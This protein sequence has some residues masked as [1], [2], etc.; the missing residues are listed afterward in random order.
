MPNVRPEHLHLGIVLKTVGLSD[1][2]TLKV[3]GLQGA[4]GFKITSGYAGWEEIE[5]PRR[6]SVVN[7]K[8]A[9]PM[10]MV[11]DLLLDTWMHVPEESVD[12]DI[13][14]LELM[15]GMGTKAP[16]VPPK[17]KLW[18]AAHEEWPAKVPHS[19]FAWYIWDLTWGDCLRNT[20][21]Q[22]KRQQCRVELVEA[23]TTDSIRRL[24]PVVNVEAP[25]T[26]HGRL[27]RTPGNPRL[28]GFWIV[29]KGDT[30]QFIAKECYQNANKWRLIA[31]ANSI[32]NTKRLVPG[33]KLKIPRL[34]Q[35]LHETSGDEGY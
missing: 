28:K 18:D 11:G 9:S 22:T 1:E 31:R 2:N 32:H 21:G 13:Y 15:A 17:I 4:E 29:K 19:N 6:T 7:Y 25:G 16:G 35:P 27:K 20:E 3:M 26:G 33:T 12:G 23:V 5:R 14:T 8:G 10:H 30:L 24:K 34:V